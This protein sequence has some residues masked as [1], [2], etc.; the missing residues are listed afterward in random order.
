MINKNDQKY[1]SSGFNLIEKSL[2]N[3]WLF[4]NFTWAGFL[5][6]YSWKFLITSKTW[7][8]KGY[9]IWKKIIQI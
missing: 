8:L 9:K 5:V 4:T 7:E 2:Q 1:A 3:F 6:N